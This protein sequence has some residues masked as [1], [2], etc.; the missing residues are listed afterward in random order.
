[1]LDDPSDLITMK[2]TA[3]I[4]ILHEKFPNRCIQKGETLED[5][6]RYAGQRQLVDILLALKAQAEDDE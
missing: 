2:A 4:E 3:L 5:A 1:M 6:H